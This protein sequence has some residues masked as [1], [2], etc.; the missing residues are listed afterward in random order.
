MIC[1]L[2]VFDFE[3]RLPAGLPPSFHGTH[4]FVRYTLEAYVD[5]PLWPDV[6]AVAELSLASDQMPPEAI[7]AAPLTETVHVP[8]AA[9]CCCGDGGVA[10]MGMALPARWLS[11]GVVALDVFAGISV[12]SSK[13]LP[14]GASLSLVETLMFTAGSAHNSSQRVLGSV[15]LSPEVYAPCE[16]RS[17]HDDAHTAPPPH[18]KP[19]LLQVSGANTPS[20]DAAGTVSVSHALVLVMPV[21]WAIAAR[22]QL[23]VW[24]HSPHVRVA[25]MPVGPPPPQWLQE[26]KYVRADSAGDPASVIVVV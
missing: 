5:I 8:L 7:S 14:Q 20:F 16:P 23:T 9:F 19:V 3:I 17:P 1:G 15:G 12:R 11:Q 26:L 22:T 21:P 18:L 24:I 4:G 2:D 6:S 10:E 13:R 25:A